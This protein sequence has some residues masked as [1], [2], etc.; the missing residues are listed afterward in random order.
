M[1]QRK[2]RQ[3]FKY[4]E[5]LGQRI[6][7]DIEDKREANVS[8]LEDRTLSSSTEGNRG[9]EEGNGLPLI[10]LEYDEFEVWQD[11]LSKKAHRQL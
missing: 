11:L 3:D 10:S 6:I 7:K 4:A 5:N 2:T 1:I 9:G 8:S